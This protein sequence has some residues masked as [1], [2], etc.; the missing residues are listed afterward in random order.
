MARKASARRRTTKRSRKC[1]R[2]M[3]KVGKCDRKRCNKNRC[4]KR[5]RK[6]TMK[7][8]KPIFYD[9]KKSSPP[10]FYGYAWQLGKPNT[11]PGVGG[12]PGA[13][14]YFALNSYKNQPG[15]NSYTNPG[16]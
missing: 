7:G 5:N 11:W 1:S 14:N 4:N 8:G 2:K 16:Y 10:P 15:Y 13:S 6:Y 12:V 9:M 3:C